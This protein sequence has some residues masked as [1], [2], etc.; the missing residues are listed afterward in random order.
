MKNLIM[1]SGD[2]SLAQGKQGAFYN[3]L[4][5]FSK[6]WNR[7]DVIVPHVSK[8]GLTHYFGNV[9][10]H[11]SPWP[12]WFQPWW[13]YRCGA[14][15]MQQQKYDF[16]TVHDYPPFYNSL[17][18]SW[19]SR[20][21]RVPFLLEIMH[22]PGLPYAG[23]FKESFYKIFTRARIA[24]IARAARAIRVINQHQTKDF[25]I[26]AG[27]PA[28]KIEYIP[29]MYIDLDVFKSEPR[30]KKYD[31]VYAARLE[32]NKGIKNLLSAVKRV[33]SNRPNVKL[34][35]IGDG[36]LRPSLEE[37]VRNHGLGPNV[38]FVGWQNQ[39][40]EV[41]Q[42]FNASKVFVNPSL[43]E[44]GPRVVLEAMACGLPTITTPVGLMIDIIK[45][46][47]NGLLCGFD[48][49]SIAESI[50]EMLN[51]TEL[52]YRC[53]RGGEYLAKQFERTKAIGEYSSA[54]ERL[55]QRRLFLITQKVD[56]HDQLLGFFVEWLR[57]LGEATS[58]QVVCLQQGSFNLPRISIQ[59]LGKEKRNSKLAQAYNFFS[60]IFLKNDQYDSVFVHMNPIWV[61]LGGWYWKFRGKKIILWYTH[62]SIT[63]KLKIASWF[64]DVILTASKESF[65]LES[66]K[67]VIT[68]HGIDIDTFRPFDQ[69]P[70]D[71]ILSVGRIAPIKNYEIL[72]EA[73][74]NFN[75]PVHVTLAGE[76][77]LSSD[78]EYERNLRKKIHDYQLDSDFSFVGK[79][80]YERLPELYNRH[81]VFAHMS[82]TGSLDKAILE[83][84][85][86]GMT[87]VSSNDAAKA[88]I[89]AAYRFAENDPQGLGEALKYAFNYPLNLRDYVVTNHNLADLIQKIVQII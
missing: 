52:Q 42:L 46:R 86:C 2:R 69:T 83:A 62:K 24:S 72:I 59:S 61:V 56:Q 34:C 26:R 35:V 63:L 87:A 47:E 27:V 43:N 67:V 79:V 23:S 22:I 80:D 7:I 73:I 29:A 89:P 12:L 66:K 4:E 9:Y 76:P 3:T 58:L 54:V 84:L 17:G 70:N 14:K 44:G 68:G 51:D 65:R 49:V 81:K 37:Y 48:S 36:P 31:I 45:N 78:K 16:I 15:L 19:L 1:I 5:E 50:E 32:K 82:K 71:S 60:Y 20:Q 77:V 25:L 74:K 30:E 11:S 64:A 57:R 8:K 85:A 40:Q 88:F 39:P 55:A 41:A 28:S 6:H 13:I 21:S 75:N 38:D 53:V 18:A 10:L 33:K